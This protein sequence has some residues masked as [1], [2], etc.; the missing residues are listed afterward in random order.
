MALTAGALALAGCSSS[1]PYEINGVAYG[2][3]GSYTIPVKDGALDFSGERVPMVRDVPK[4]CRA[5]ANGNQQEAGASGCQLILFA[6]GDYDVF[7]Y[8]APGSASPKLVSV[9]PIVP[10]GSSG[11]GIPDLSKSSG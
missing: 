6:N 11:D 4:H 7:R 10:P 9:G 2:L 8:T 3:N 1:N 5:A